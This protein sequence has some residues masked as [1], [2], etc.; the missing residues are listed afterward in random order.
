FKPANL[1]SAYELAKLQK[2]GAPG[3]I[4]LHYYTH[5]K[6][7]ER[8]HIHTKAMSVDGERAIV[9]SANM[10]GRSLSSPFVRRDAD[11]KLSQAMYNKEMS[12]LLEGRQF[13]QEIDE[14]LFQDDMSKRT[15][16]MD[17]DAILKAVQD[18]GGEAELRKKA[19]AAP[20]T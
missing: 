2:A 9:G 11:G 13:V 10:I 6:G 15:K 12:L 17:A 5:E 20:F 3:Q 18:A 14:R 1:L 16:A 4:Q 7:G 19:V 8:N